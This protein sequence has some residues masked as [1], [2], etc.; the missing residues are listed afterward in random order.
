LHKYFEINELYTGYRGLAEAA[1]PCLVPVNSLAEYAPEPNPETKKKDLVWFA[2]SNNRATRHRGYLGRVKRRPWDQIETASRPSPRP[3]VL[4]ARAE[5]GGRA[6][7]L[8]IVPRGADEEDV[9]A[10]EAH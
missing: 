6:D 5:C 4:D 7:A 3:W 2:L 8:K 9:A 10:A 1:K